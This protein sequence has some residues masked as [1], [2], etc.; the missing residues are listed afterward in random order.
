[1]LTPPSSTSNFSH[2]SLPLKKVTNF[3]LAVEGEYEQLDI[4]QTDWSQQVPASLEFKDCRL[5]HCNF[6]GLKIAKLSLI[7]VVLENCD[8]ANT[9]IGELYAKDVDFQKC[10]LTGCIANESILNSVAYKRCQLQFAQFRFTKLKKVIFRDSPLNEADFYAANLWRVN[11]Y[12][13]DLTRAEMSCSHHLD[14]DLSSSN[15]TGLKIGLDSLK[16]ITINQIQINDL[17]WL[18]GVNII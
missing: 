13:C 4:S 10:R 2:L 18:L 9:E 12:N 3:D 5:Q 7:N 11:F 15:I 1:M 6:N 8:L 17:A 16:G 14:T